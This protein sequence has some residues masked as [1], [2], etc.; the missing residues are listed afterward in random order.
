MFLSHKLKAA[1]RRVQTFK[2]LLQ[3]RAQNKQQQ[4]NAH[5]RRVSHHLRFL[6]FFSGRDLISPLFPILGLR[7]DLQFS[8][9]YRTNLIAR[10]CRE[11]VL[12]LLL[13]V[14]I[15]QTCPLLPTSFSTPLFTYFG[16]CSSKPKHNKQ[17]AN[18]CKC[19]DKVMGTRLCRRWISYFNGNEF[20]D[21]LLFL[22]AVTF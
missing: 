7:V 13:I 19:G 8:L 5:W 6:I 1:H 3:D 14:M 17:A 12:L 18:E 20:L 15:M 9:T 10:S 11:S 22:F 21:L 16:G 2:Q 4:K